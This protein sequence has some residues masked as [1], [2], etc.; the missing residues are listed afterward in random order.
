MTSSGNFSTAILATYRKLSLSVVE[1]G[2]KSFSCIINLMI[3]ITVV[4]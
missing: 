1:I 2:T 3:Y 4:T